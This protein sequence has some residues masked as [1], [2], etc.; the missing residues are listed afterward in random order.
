M[1][2]VTV[3]VLV[4]AVLV[5]GGIAFTTLGGTGAGTID[6]ELTERWIS[7]TPRNN[8]FNHHAVGAGDGLVVA[9]L[10]AVPGSGV[11]MTE[12][13]CSLVRLAPTDGGVDWQT[14]MPPEQCFTHALTQPAIGD[15]DGDSSPEISVG[16]TADATIIYAAD[17]SEQARLPQSTY[18]YGQPTVGNVTA[19]PGPELVSSD[20]GGTVTVASGDGTVHWQRNVS[21]TVWASPVVADVDADD[22]PEV[23]VGASDRTVAFDA[24]GTIVWDVDVAGQD[25][26]AGQADDD[27]AVE[28]IGT[29]SAAERGIVA[30]DGRSGTIEWEYTVR[31]T[32]TVH[33][34]ADADGDGDTEVYFAKP[35]NVVGALNATAGDLE[36][37]TRL[38]PEENTPTPA[39]V[40]GDLTG[41]GQRELVTVTSSGTVTVLNP[42]SGEQLAVYE[43][44]T[45]VWTFPTVADLT[46][47]PG[48][49]ILVR[50]GDGRVAALAYT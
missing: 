42:T 47:D 15:I 32:P 13:S 21:A 50:Y 9:P 3:L 33:S 29:S 40:L 18:G 22:A 31:G 36:W 7:D 12:R 24:D 5:F 39:P 44:E 14:T 43:R 41:D 35:G 23:V 2:P 11:E 10:A 48:A 26:R 38:A 19:A 25:L 17:G 30:I 6:G 4:G 46:D 1:R 20:I 37:T 45:P 28:L 49:E 8:T 16:T 34:V 27:P